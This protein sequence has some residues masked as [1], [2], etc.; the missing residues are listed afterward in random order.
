[1]GV[2]LTI[3]D[4][5]VVARC[6]GAALI[7]GL[8][9]GLERQWRQGLGGMRTYT[10]VS[11]G[12]ALFVRAGMMLPS[13]DYTR[14]AAQ[15]ASGIGFLCAGVI[16]KQ[17]PT[18]RGL[19]QAAT[20][21]CSCAIGVL[22]GADLLIPALAGTIC[23]LFVNLVVRSWSLDMEAHFLEN[24]GAMLTYILE[25]ECAQS[26]ANVLRAALA[27]NIAQNGLFRLSSVATDEGSTH[28]YRAI[29][30]DLVSRGRADEQVEQIVGIL[31]QLPGVKS[32]RWQ[33]AGPDGATQSTP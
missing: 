17:G 12:A 28:G 13:T 6:L 4:S 30:G 8:I 3:A 11:L 7:L 29:R 27:T 5:W 18:V 25:I 2:P 15:V 31:S 33:L 14:F 22:C 20:I 21:W 32:I 1:M 10:L 23:V 19:N 16:F 24:P 26:Q 9:I